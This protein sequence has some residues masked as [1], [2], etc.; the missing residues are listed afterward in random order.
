MNLRTA[1]RTIL[2]CALW[3]LPGAVGAEENNDGTGLTV[4]LQVWLRREEAP[5]AQARYT[6]II[7]HGRNKF[8]F[9]VPSG[10]VLRSDPA[11]GTL[12]LANGEGN[13]SVTFSML[14]PRS[15]DD[16]PAFTL[17]G[18][19]EPLLKDYPSGK[20]MQEFSHTTVGGPG[21]GFDLQWKVSGSVAE[22]KRV[23]YVSTKAG[24]LQFTATSGKNN[25][26]AVKA[27][28]DSM[29][30]TLSFSTDGVL[31]VPPLTTDS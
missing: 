21:F 16:A 24:I 22:Y 26:D 10:F 13:C 23:V 25:F 29:I 14:T 9:R 20:I 28:L 31:K 4:P 8:A 5:Y 3:A 18:Y 19:R 17:D 12:K 1:I 7:T 2:F 6:A 11:S 30:M 27:E 15:A